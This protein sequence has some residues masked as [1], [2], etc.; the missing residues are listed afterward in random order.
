LEDEGYAIFNVDNLP[1]EPDSILNPSPLSGY[2][3]LDLTKPIKIK[4]NKRGREEISTIRSYSPVNINLD[5]LILNP[6][7]LTIEGAMNNIA[8]ADQLPLDYLPIEGDI[9]QVF[10]EALKR[11]YEKTYV[12][13]DKPYYY[14]GERIWFKA[15][16]KYYYKPWQDSLSKTMYVELI[17]ANKKI[18]M[19][20]TI[21]LDN[22]ISFNDF[23]LPDTISPGVY[24]LRTYT[25]LQ[26][27]FGE[28]KLFMKTIPI[29]NLSDKIIYSQLAKPPIGNQLLKIEASKDT[30][31]TRGKINLILK[32]RDKNGKDL[33]GN[34]SISVTDASQVQVLPEQSMTEVLTM[35]NEEIN[36][37]KFPVEYGITLSGQFLGERNKPNK[38]SLYLM[39]TNPNNHKVQEGLLRFIQSK[40]IMDRRG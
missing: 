29:L 7:A 37:F 2:Y 35:R 30:F 19:D 12:H 22:S 3:T 9:N 32:L 15:Y 36:S 4:Y 33:K 8:I 10:K 11:S 31:H 6:N 20:K 14:P 34:F 21:R 16:M 23:I 40:D 25:N 24:H 13:T 1:I 27:N 39:Q 28:E 38:V 26:R 18:V 5:G 17:N